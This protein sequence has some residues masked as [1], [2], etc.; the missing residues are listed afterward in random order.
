MSW[1]KETKTKFVGWGPDGVKVK[2]LDCGIVLNKFELQS[3]Y[4]IHFWTNTLGKN[5]KPPL[6][7]KL[8]VK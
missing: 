7:T 1:N 5:M 6:S 3:C 2:A 4:Y 8:C